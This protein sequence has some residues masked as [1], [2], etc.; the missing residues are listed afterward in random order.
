MFSSTARIARVRFDVHAR[1]CLSRVDP[2]ERRCAATP[3]STPQIRSTARRPDL[4][5]PDGAPR[6]LR[7]RPGVGV[8]DEARRKS[9][10]PA[11]VGA[12]LILSQSGALSS[13]RERSCTP[14]RIGDRTSRMLLVNGSRRIEPTGEGRWGET[15]ANSVARKSNPATGATPSSR[16][17]YDADARCPP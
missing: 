16:M 11:R 4:D 10:H 1:I 6:L 2:S 15:W 9:T 3:A 17:R 7:S 13:R 8:R 5:S 14:P 12:Q